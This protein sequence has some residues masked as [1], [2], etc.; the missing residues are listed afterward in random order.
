MPKGEVHFDISPL[1][2]EAL[3]INGADNIA[4]L[5]KT[6]PGQSLGP[7]GKVASGGELARISLAIQVATA[8]TRNIP[9]FCLR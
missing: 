4:L 7:L 8:G 3:T 9:T 1:P 5:V 2:N 6:N